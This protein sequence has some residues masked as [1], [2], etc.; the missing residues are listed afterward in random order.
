[1]GRDDCRR[2]LTP[3]ALTLP[4]LTRARG[5]LAARDLE[6]ETR[7]QVRRALE[8]Q[9]EDG[10]WGDGSTPT[11]RVLPTLWMTKTLLE[12]GRGGDASVREAGGF[13]ATTACTDEGVF[14]L[15][16]R[17]SGVLSC[18]VGTAASIFV[19]L[20]FSES[21]RA[22]VDWVLRYQDVRC[23][24]ASWREQP[25]E[26]WS[27]D[28][29]WRYGGCLAST[30]CLI[31]LARTGAGLVAWREH[32]G[33]TA[34][35]ALLHQ[36]AEAFLQ[37]SLFQKTDGSTLPLGTPP[38]RA[39][40]WLLPT[41]PRDWRVDLIEVLHLVARV[42]GPDPRLQPALNVVGRQQLADGSW[43]LR[44][45][46]RPAALPL[47]ERRSRSSGSTVITQRVVAALEGLG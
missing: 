39:D 46:F 14:S 21:A 32:T 41:F 47:L 13:L 43:R 12:L 23:G 20:G 2:G 24:G 38:S 15:D 6:V 42:A 33:S 34:G 37:R 5:W 35:D 36:V 40:E 18:Y 22:Q 8:H 17:R 3:P 31:G 26:V 29:A 11:A 9:R 28:L 45:S 19:A 16:G 30:T 7:D 10:S 27:P 4:D 1:M 44:R 25:V